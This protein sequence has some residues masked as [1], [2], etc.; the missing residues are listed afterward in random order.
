MLD[1]AS[2]FN[3]QST[4]KVSQTSIKESAIPIQ[5]YMQKC[6][7]YL[8]DKL[9]K[10]FSDGTWNNERKKQE[11]DARIRDFIMQNLVRVEGFITEQD[12][13][14]AEALLHYVIDTFNGEGVLKNALEDPNIDE[15][16][17][18][19]YKTI[20]VFDRGV[21]RYCVDSKGNP[22][23]F[24]DN[25]AVDRF[26]QRLCDDGLGN[27]PQF[28]TGNPILNAKTAYKQYRI[29]AV[30]SSLNARERGVHAEPITTVTLR[31]FPEHHLTLEDLVKSNTITRKLARL[32][33]LVGLVNLNVHFV[34]RTGSG[35]TTLLQA[36]VQS[37][38]QNQGMILIQN[39][40]EIT[41]FDRDDFGRNKRNVIHWESQDNV[42]S[43][44][45]NNGTTT[46]LLATVLRNTPDVLI[47]GEARYA[48]EFAG[49]A[50]AGRM[51]I[52]L[53]STYHAK[54]AVG[55]ISRGA[56]MLGMYNHVPQNEMMVTWAEA[57]NIIVVQ[58]KW[59]ENGERKIAELTEVLVD[60]NTQEIT[61]R[62]IVVFQ[63]DG[64]Y[65]DEKGVSH[66]KGKYVMKN[67][68]SE[69]FVSG[70]RDALVPD[71]EY[72]EFLE[73]GDMYDE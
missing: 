1:T 63:E 53:I 36:V 56:N 28:N 11:R 32:L 24:P 22:V 46:N 51:S 23:Q 57:A 8:R 27:I 55:A 31:K 12:E 66:I 38:P 3:I 68:I 15:I 49:L 71:E 61:Y 52:R 39:P 21:K 40:T 16:Q 5:D 58:K 70:L 35:K 50:T 13:V 69:V 17:I 59:E 9:P 54:N 37:I 34:G 47:L 73:I 67:T 7:T 64:V 6:E 60:P 65:V 2:I 29:N 20:F 18:R 33:K 42:D 62:P 44:N 25:D 72:A 4:Y 19:D 30:Y 26:V 10:E 14:N 41:F 45:K 48:D 43:N